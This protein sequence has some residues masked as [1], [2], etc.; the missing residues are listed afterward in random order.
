MK[1]DEIKAQQAK[2]EKIFNT[3]SLKIQGDNNINIDGN[4]NKIEINHYTKTPKKQVEVYQHDSDIHISQEQQIHV[5]EL[6]SQIGDM[7]RDVLKE[8]HYSHVY[9]ALNHKLHVNSYK[10]IPKTDF[11]KA[12]AF[13]KQKQKILLDQLCIVNATR[14]KEYIIPLIKQIWHINENNDNFLEFDDLLDYATKIT[15][16]NKRDIENFS[17]VDLRKIY[18]KLLMDYKK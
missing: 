15:K 7:C 17:A 2:R 14:Y 5:R 13:L 18:R 9:S 3:K 11:N 4:N 8:G 10:L 6:V 16:T 12:I 1:T